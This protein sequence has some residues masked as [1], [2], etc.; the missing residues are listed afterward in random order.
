LNLNTGLTRLAILGALLATAT[1]AWIARAQ[2]PALDDVDSRIEEGIAQVRIRLTF[3]VR[4]LRHFPADHGEQLEIYFQAAA[5]STQD[6]SLH[7]EVRRV[8][9][10]PAIPG[11][12]VTYTPP[13]LRDL[14]REPASLLIKF[15]RPVTFK[16][17]PGDDKE[18]I[19]L[20]LP[21][22]PA[23]SGNP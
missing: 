18:S 6:I 5:L 9:P 7:Q 22:T 8:S 12:T 20:Y 11:F 17:S 3:P 19:Y 1:F 10:T 16:V 23:P 4:Y 13:P 15:D 14:D 21:V 2:N